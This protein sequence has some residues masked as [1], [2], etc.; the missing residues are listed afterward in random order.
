MKMSDRQRKPFYRRPAEVFMPAYIEP[1][2]DGL[3]ERERYLV[4]EL[5]RA[6]IHSVELGEGGAY[7]MLYQIGRLANSFT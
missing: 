7:E 1:A 6:L 5:N 2:M 3:S 4:R